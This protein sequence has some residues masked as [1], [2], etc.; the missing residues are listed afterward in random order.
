MELQSRL[1]GYP[2]LHAAHLS[3]AIAVLHRLLLM[4]PVKRCPRLPGIVLE[5]A[6]QQ[7]PARSLST[8]LHICYAYV[9][10]ST[11]SVYKHS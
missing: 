5:A 10:E 9:T 1:L 2:G 11:P 3:E 4:G 7:S 6:S 8:N